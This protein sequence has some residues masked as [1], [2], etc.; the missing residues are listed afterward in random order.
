MNRTERSPSGSYLLAD[1]GGTNARFAFVTEDSAR[2]QCITRLVCAD[3]QSLEDAVDFYLQPLREKYRLNLLGACLAVA[4]PVHRDLIQL[5][6]NPWRFSKQDLSRTLKVPV[7]VLNDFSAQAYFLTELQPDDVVWWQRPDSFTKLDTVNPGP[8]TVVGPGT[9]FGA[10]TI[11]VG[12]EVIESEPGH[13]SFAPVNDHEV[14]LLQ[15]LWQRYD[16]VSP[17]HLLSGPGL[18]NLYWANRSLQAMPDID[19]QPDAA[20]VVEQ[21]EAGDALALQSLHDFSAIMGSVCG[22]IAL[23]MGS[24]GGIY[25]SGAML[26]RMGELFDIELFLTRFRAKGTFRHWCGEVPVGRLALS[27]PGLAGCAV[28]ARRHAPADRLP[29]GPFREDDGRQK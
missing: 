6:N 1:I 5:T 11:T 9:G 12:G 7:H 16:R 19:N 20:A 29:D 10:S 23:S 4:A 24:L 26:E 15:C 22:D 3:F 21:A 8:R 25:L 17:E 13:V 2:L 14:Q 18:A 28:F 27:L